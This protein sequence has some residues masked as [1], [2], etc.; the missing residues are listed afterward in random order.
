LSAAINPGQT[1]RAIKA[2]ALVLDGLR[3]G[4]D[5]Q[6]V[7][8]A[9]SAQLEAGRAAALLGPNG[10]GKS[11]LLKVVLG[12]LEPWSGEVKVFGH[13]P[14]RLNRRRWQI[15]YVPQ[16]RTVDRAFPAT[17][18][19]LAMMGRVGRLG[20]FR[21]P[22]A[23]DRELALGALSDVG[24]A[25]LVG[26]PFGALSGGQQQRAFLARA[27]AQE[28]DL[29]VLDEPA[30]GVDAASRTAIGELLSGLRARGVPVLVATHELDELQPFTFDQHWTL[31]GGRLYVD[32]PGASHQP[33]P[34]DRHE[35][36]PAERP[37]AR[38]A[39]RFGGWLQF[40]SR[41]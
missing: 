15:G 14:Q 5:G 25:Q 38:R 12:L 20:L 36:L 34:A 13:R 10:S 2:T 11:T 23:R 9:A 29:L 17:V 32:L 4:Y 26:R 27:L 39:S 22:T 37:A 30:A 1:E 18:F 8:L 40:P 31:V 7:V 3:T 33:H 24:L 16:L 21:R 41:G 28:P 19:D 6:A 35:D